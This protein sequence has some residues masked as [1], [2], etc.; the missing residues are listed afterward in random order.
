MGRTDSSLSKNSKAALQN[1]G[2]PG[3]VR[4][5]ENA[6][7]RALLLS[8]HSVIEPADLELDDISGTKIASNQSVSS[9]NVVNA[10]QT[11]PEGGSDISSLERDHILK[12]LVQVNGNRKKAV[13]V[14]GISERA[15]RYKLKAYK[16]AGF[17]FE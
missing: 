15:L 9:A 1:Y 6:I 7:Q 2:W 10:P 13:S 11:G 3:N 5:L 16:D 14:L 4:E 17:E 12:V 8:D